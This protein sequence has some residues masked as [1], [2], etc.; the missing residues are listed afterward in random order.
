MD[1]QPSVIGY[2]PKRTPTISSAVGVKSTPFGL[3][4]Q[5]RP[6]L[7]WLPTRDLHRE[8]AGRYSALAAAIREASDR[9]G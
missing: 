8:L 6:L 3:S 4:N 2:C 5:T 1:C 7:L 9:T